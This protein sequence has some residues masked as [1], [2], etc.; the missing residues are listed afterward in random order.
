MEYQC[1]LWQ[2]ALL[3]LFNQSK[4]PLSGEDSVEI[5]MKLNN[6][7][8]KS[9]VDYTIFNSVEQDALTPKAKKPLPFPL[10][11]NGR[12]NWYCI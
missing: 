4:L 2:L 10:E 3:L 7:K 5:K 9:I 6:I 1:N 12:R 11:N 8:M